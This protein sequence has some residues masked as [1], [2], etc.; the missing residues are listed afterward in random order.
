MRLSVKTDIGYQ[1]YEQQSGVVVGNN[2][3][4]R[5][6]FEEWFKDLLQFSDS[7]EFKLFASKLEGA[8]KKLQTAQGQEITRFNKNLADLQLLF[9][10]FTALAGKGTL[11][12]T[13]GLLT[14]FNFGD[15]DAATYYLAK[16]EDLPSRIRDRTGGTV[17]TNSKTALDNLVADVQKA[18]RMNDAFQQHLQN[19]L[20]ELQ[21]EDYD[22]SDR[23]KLY[24]WA[25][26]NM[27]NRFKENQGQTPM[28]LAR[29][30]WGNGHIHGYTAEAYGTHL[31]LV[32]NDFMAMEHTTELA[33]SV[34]AEHGGRGSRGLF[35]LLNSTKGNTS[36]QL[37]GDIVIVNPDGTIRFNIQSKASI[38]SS[39]N[40]YITYQKFLSNVY[41]FLSIYKNA[42]LNQAIEQQDIDTLFKAFST[43]AWTP[44]SKDINKNISTEVDKFLV[45]K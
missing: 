19:F 9:L 10:S 7:D 32:H 6:D 30:F 44:I 21:E 25:Y 3:L 5:T 2:F 36:S 15:Q 4:N 42:A 8:V 18:Q 39:Y 33:K 37:S 29:Y 12:G 38:K 1:L 13:I 45:L 23:R 26:Y 14:T 34:I 41:S 24:I 20:V 16:E 17:F 11:G 27:K 43:E 28:S 31:S 40:I 22:E 35:N